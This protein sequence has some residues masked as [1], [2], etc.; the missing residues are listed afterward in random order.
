MPAVF[1]GLA[2][3]PTIMGG[4]AFPFGT[5]TFV[6]AAAVLLAIFLVPDRYRELVAGLAATFASPRWIPYNPSYLQV[7]VSH[8]QQKDEAQEPAAAPP[9]PPPDR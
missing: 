5:L 8:A 6:L 4:T 2:N 3:Y 7:G 9:P 1:L